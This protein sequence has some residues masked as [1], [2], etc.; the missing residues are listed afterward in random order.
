M[1]YK[2]DKALHGSVKLSFYNTKGYAYRHMAQT[3]SK[4]VIKT[5][6]YNWVSSMI[7]VFLDSHDFVK[8]SNKFANFMYIW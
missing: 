6:Q 5:L 8:I 7:N 1:D 4:C 2:H 3:N